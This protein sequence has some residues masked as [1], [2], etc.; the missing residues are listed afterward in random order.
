MIDNQLSW[1]VSLISFSPIGQRHLGDSRYSTN[2]AALL[3]LSVIYCCFVFFSCC[4]QTFTSINDVLISCARRSLAYPLYRHWSLV[5]AVL[6]D[7]KKIFSLGKV[8]VL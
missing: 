8:A 7:T 3:C 1:N 2:L 4:P 6:E 5:V